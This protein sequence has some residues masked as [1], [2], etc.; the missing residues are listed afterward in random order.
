MWLVQEQSSMEPGPRHGTGCGSTV[1]SLSP[2]NS[3]CLFIYLIF[4]SPFTPSMPS[5]ISTPAPKRGK[6]M[7]VK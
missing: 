7:K 4:P 3:V 2:H 5:S 6:Q 1:I